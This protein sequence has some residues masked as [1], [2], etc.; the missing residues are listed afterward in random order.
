MSCHF[1]EC[2]LDARAHACEQMRRLF[3]IGR[4]RAGI[5]VNDDPLE[6]LDALSR[7]RLSPAATDC[8]QIGAG[9][10]GHLYID[11]LQSTK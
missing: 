4:R 11:K 1:F 2:P 3:L 9:S 6:V 7:G 8:A 5:G 10:S